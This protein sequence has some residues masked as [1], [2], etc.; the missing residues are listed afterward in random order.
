VDSLSAITPLHC[1]SLRIVDDTDRLLRAPEVRFDASE[2]GLK[3]FGTTSRTN[4]GC[5]AS[6]AGAGARNLTIVNEAADMSS[7]VTT[8]YHQD[9]KRRDDVGAAAVGGRCGVACRLAPA[10]STRT[11][12]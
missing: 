7:R 4:I 5:G 12:H 9:A 8:A 6:C 3:E 11:R 10:I 2:I 1:A